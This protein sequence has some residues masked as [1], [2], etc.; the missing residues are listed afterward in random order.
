MNYQNYQS[1][2]ITSNDIVPVSGHAVN[3]SVKEQ[4]GNIYVPSFTTI[5]AIP[6]ITKYIISIT[7]LEVDITSDSEVSLPPENT[8]VDI[9]VDDTMYSECLKIGG[10]LKDSEIMK[11]SIV[12]AGTII[13]AGYI[14]RENTD[15]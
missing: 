12:F 8:K 11:E 1:V 10:G 6:K 15:E 9:Q 2:T 7:D 4:A 13:Y 5:L 3:V 14:W